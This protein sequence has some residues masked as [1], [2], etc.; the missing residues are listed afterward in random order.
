M[1]YFVIVLFMSLFVVFVWGL[2]ESDK[3]PQ[4][5]AKSIIG[6]FLF[7]HLMMNFFGLLMGRFHEVF[8][9]SVYVF[10]LIALLSL[11]NTFLKHGDQT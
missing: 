5:Q 8:H 1:L 4:Q 6:A 3:T 10:A 11:F 9:A 2:A 7:T